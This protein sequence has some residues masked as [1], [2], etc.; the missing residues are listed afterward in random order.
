MLMFLT[1]ILIAALLVGGGIASLTYNAVSFFDL[2][3]WLVYVMG[4]ISGI[5]GAIAMA[6][7]MI[8]R[9]DWH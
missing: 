6:A 9:I 2:P 1:Y 3:F 4:G 7:Y 8:T 5:V